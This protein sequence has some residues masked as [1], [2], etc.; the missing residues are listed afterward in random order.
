[1]RRASV[2]VSLALAACGTEPE[3]AK[4]VDSDPVAVETDT[5][6][7]EVRVESDEPGPPPKDPSKD[8][9]AFFDVVIEG[10][11]TVF[12]AARFIGWQAASAFWAGPQA[13]AAATRVRRCL[14]VQDM[15]DWST[16]GNPKD[17][18]PLA[19]PVA[20]C[21]GCEFAFTVTLTRPVEATYLPPTQ[22]AIDSDTDT[23]T[24]AVLPPPDSVPGATLN[25]TSVQRQTRPLSDFPD[26]VGVGFDADDPNQPTTLGTVLLWIPEA[27]GTGGGWQ[28]YDYSATWDQ[29]A[30]TVTWDWTTQYE[31]VR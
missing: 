29:V 15:I 21:P 4:P 24:D 3:P 23:D 31:Y 13:Q 12:P 25:C 17:Q 8:T 7:G 27:T 1:M 22:D 9:G 30:S 10:K 20:N 18:D 5:G 14:F 2:I 11:A 6:D 26:E 19:T 28:P 16:A